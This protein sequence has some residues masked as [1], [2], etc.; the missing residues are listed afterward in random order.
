M[1]DVLIHILLGVL[2]HIL[3]RLYTITDFLKMINRDYSNLLTALFSFLLFLVTAVYV[4]YTYVQVGISKKSIAL[5]RD[6]L[7]QL[8]NEHKTSVT[9]VL[10]SDG[11]ST[12]GGACYPLNGSSNRRLMVLCNIKNIGNSPAIKIYTKI[13]LKF[14][15]E[16]YKGRVFSSEYHYAGSLAIN[17]KNT[18]VMFFDG[19]KVSLLLEEISVMCEQNTNTIINHTGGKLAESTTLIIDCVYSNIHSQYF[20]TCYE[21]GVHG[22]TA[23][24]SKKNERKISR[25]DVP[26]LKDNEEFELMFVDPSYSHLDIGPLNDI[27]AEE[28]INGYRNA[29]VYRNK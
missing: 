17:D 18:S 12:H 7:K 6:Y 9:P 4:I 5:N 27:D 1:L 3:F 13:G 20:K 23:I 2:V 25:S 10:V 24:D 11:V 26:M 8:E 28:F 19:E 21:I 15:F 29:V 14:K 16:E 22:I